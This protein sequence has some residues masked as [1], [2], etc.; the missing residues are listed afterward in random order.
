MHSDVFVFFLKG[1]FVIKDYCNIYNCQMSTVQR[2]LPNKHKPVNEV[3][4][5]SRQ[6]LSIKEGS[7]S[8]WLHISTS[9]QNIHYIRSHVMP[10]KTR[11]Y[12]HK[13][14]LHTKYYI[15]FPTI[16]CSDNYNKL[17]NILTTRALNKWCQE[18]GKYRKCSQRFV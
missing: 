12:L 18:W 13:K 7:L 3:K 5:A 1:N 6:A 8:F 16:N 14:K 2:S 9:R 15:L 10:R 11:K 17:T 4:H